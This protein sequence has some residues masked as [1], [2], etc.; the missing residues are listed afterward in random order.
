MINVAV[1]MMM[2]MVDEEVVDVR[3]VGLR[4]RRTEA[5]VELVTT[6]WLH[7]PTTHRFFP[8]LFLLP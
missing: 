8:G 1:M 4:R 7:D 2:W 3:G 5:T 6:R